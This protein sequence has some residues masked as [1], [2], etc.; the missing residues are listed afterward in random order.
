MKKSMN[1]NCN[2]GFKRIFLFI[3]AITSIFFILLLGRTSLISLA[4]IYDEIF[5]LLAAR[6]FAI[7]G[8]LSILDG[9]YDRASIY[10]RLVAN[11]FKLFDSTSLATGRLWASSVP[12]S[13]LPVL[14]LLWSYK[15]IGIYCS[16][17]LFLFLF[18]WPNGIEVSQFM[19]FYSIQGLLFFLIF[20]LFN[21]FI[22][23]NRA[24]F[25][26][27]PILIFVVIIVYISVTIQTTTLIGLSGLLLSVIVLFLLRMGW[28]IRPLYLALIIL[29]TALISSVLL[30]ATAD[31][32][33]KIWTS[34]QSAPPDWPHDIFYYHRVMR[35]NYPL[36]WTLYP[37]ACIVALH[38][39]RD[40]SIVCIS[41]FS[42]TIIT[43]SFGV[44]N[45]EKF[46]YFVMPFFFIVWAITLHHTYRGIYVFVKNNCSLV[47]KGLGFG[48]FYYTASVFTSVFGVFFFVFLANPAFQRSFGL[49][50]GAS[51]SSFLGN[52]RHLWNLGEKYRAEASRTPDVVIT[53]HPM[54]HILY[55]GDF[56]IVYNR[57][58]LWD[59]ENAGK[60]VETRLLGDATRSVDWRYGRIVIG[61]QSD[62]LEVVQ[63]T[64]TGEITTVYGKYAEVLDDLLPL[65][66]DGGSKL[67]IFKNRGF[68]SLTWAWPT[69]V[70]RCPGF[71]TLRGS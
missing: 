27:V 71:E 24:S 2:F 37:L 3:T 58:A 23:H 63:C 66:E 41:I 53:T 70:K 28:Q 64:Q 39:N 45:D 10:T 21:R 19:R 34:F 50:S 11:F 4:P 52:T 14:I 67:K 43:L 22:M 35:G 69:P 54:T 46:I 9:E 38:Y 55:L 1:S 65:I 32:L 7:D 62:L 33:S 42:I 8:R 31:V 57:N 18:F 29:G 47:V 13:L 40:V 51:E 59:V 16:I 5:H 6:Q 20:L 68:V 60:S 25:Y 26:D 15:Y 48:G 49:M 30:I 61:E 44:R 56:D 12:G 36:F 17:F